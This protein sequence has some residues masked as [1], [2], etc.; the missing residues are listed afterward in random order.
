MQQTLPRSEDSSQRRGSPTFGLRYSELE[1]LRLACED[2]LTRANFSRAKLLKL[3][4]TGVR[5]R[6]SQTS[7]NFRHWKIADNVTGDDRRNA[8]F[9]CRRGENGDTHPRTD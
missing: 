6:L 5:T 8:V 7:A 3:S 9:H 1:A 4:T 2:F